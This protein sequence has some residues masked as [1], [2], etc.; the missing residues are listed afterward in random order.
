MRSPFSR[1]SPEKAHCLL[2]LRW[3]SGTLASGHI[4]TAL[5]STSPATV[6][7]PSAGCRPRSALG[8]CCGGQQDLQQQ[9]QQQQQQQEQ[10]RLRRRAPSAFLRPAPG[11]RQRPAAIGGWWLLTPPTPWSGARGRLHAVSKAPAAPGGSWG[12]AAFTTTRRTR[13]VQQWQ[14]ARRRYSGVNG[15]RRERSAGGLRS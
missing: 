10:Q 3:R 13:P 12:T 5:S 15:L 8:C 1:V 4:A 9:Q 6:R 2:M 14:R 7:R 11:V